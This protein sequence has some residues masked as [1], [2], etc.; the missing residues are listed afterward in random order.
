MVKAQNGIYGLGI[1]PLCLKFQ[2][3]N[4][5]INC[6]PIIYFEPAFLGGLQPIQTMVLVWLAMQYFE[7]I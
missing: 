6:S 3:S 5:V 1:Y 2:L 4:S 7:P